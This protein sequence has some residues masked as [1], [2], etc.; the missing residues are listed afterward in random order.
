MNDVLDLSQ[1]EAGRMALAREWVDCRRDDARVRSDAVRVLFESKGLYLPDQR[2]RRCR[3]RCFCDRTRIR[4]VLLNLLSNAGR[5]TERGRGHLR[6]WQAEGE[7]LLVSVTDT[8][9]GI[10]P[11]DQQRIFE[12]FQQVDS[13]IRRREGGQ[14]A[15]AEHQQALRGDCTA[16]GCGWK[17]SL[18]RARRSTSAL[19][20]R[21]PARDRDHGPP[22]PAP[23]PIFDIRARVDRSPIGAPP[24][25]PA[26]YVLLDES[27]LLVKLLREFA[28]QAE[29]V[30][31][32][33]VVDLVQTAHHSPATALAIN[34]SH[35]QQTLAQIQDAG[36]IPQDTPLMTCWIPGQR[37]AAQ[38]LGVLRY[39]VK[40]IS[41]EG[42]LSAVHDVKADLRS[43]L[44]VD[45]NPE[46]VQLFSRMLTSADEPLRILRATN[47]QQALALIRERSPDVVLLDLVMPNMDGFEVLRVKEQDPAIREIP[48]VV[49]FVA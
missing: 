28:P 6:A 18:A 2:C 29:V 31:A 4:Q 48:V 45:D 13:S 32:Q 9:P 41:Q 34:T 7:A 40:P 22:A 17:A 1:V 19:P 24:S 12:P 33:D 35:P 36:G 43:V 5:F 21:T 15:G 16:A 10:P 23:E 3:S 42:L 25:V 39:L 30:Q 38:E 11:A 44:V 46:A 14:R 37:Q 47:G 26:R 8:G 49:G 20:S 27:G